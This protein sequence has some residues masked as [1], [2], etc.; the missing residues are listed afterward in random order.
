MK[1]LRVLVVDDNAAHAE[2]LV[3]CLKQC[4][5]A[6]GAF[7]VVESRHADG[8]RAVLA[9]EPVDVA[10][11]DYQLGAVSGL[12]LI[13]SVR[14]SGDRRPVIV[15][16]AHG[17]EYV[18]VEMI[19]AGAD[20]YISKFDLSPQRVGAAIQRVLERRER[21]SRDDTQRQEAVRRLL[22][23]TRREREVLD[24]IVAGLMN[25]QIAETMHRSEKTIKIHRA[26]V[27]N[28]MQANTAADLVRMVMTARLGEVPPSRHRVEGDDPEPDSAIAGVQH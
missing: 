2:L 13:R 6:I 1:P 17:D 24:H 4:N 9:E 25:R 8:A 19:R 11:V 15:T 10:F 7:E 27:M 18:A 28:K 3:N 5:G 14:D 21:E 12:D 26:N 23:L 22:T 20:D 16:T